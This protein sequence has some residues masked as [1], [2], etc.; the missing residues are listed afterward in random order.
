MS[1]LP[2]FKTTFILRRPG[3]A[4]FADI[5]KIAIMLAKTNFK[6]HCMKSVQIRS[7]Y[8]P[9]FDELGLIRKNT[10]QKISVFEHFSR[11]EMDTL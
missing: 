2:L 11:S 3:V 5:I 8:G 1:L 9:Y 6:R 4:N 10:D 7:F